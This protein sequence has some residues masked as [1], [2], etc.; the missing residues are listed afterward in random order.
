M[1]K[2]IVFS[3]FLFISLDINAQVFNASNLSLLWAI[4]FIL[5]ILSIA[6]FPV[7]I[8]HLWHNHYGK[9]IFFITLIFLIIVNINYGFNFTYHLV[10]HSILSE[11]LPF[12]ILLFSLYTVSSGIFLSGSVEG[13]PKNNTIMLLIGSILSSLMGTTGSTMLLIRPLIRANNERKSKA[14]IFVFLIILVAN[15]GGGLTPIGDP[16][17]FLGFL[18]GVSF[19]WNFKSMLLPVLFN[20]FIL[21]FVFYFID[22]YYYDKEDNLDN[23]KEK[24]KIS[25]YGKY[26][27]LLILLI[28]F[29]VILFGLHKTQ[30]DMQTFEIYGINLSDILRDVLLFIIAL[31][32]LYFTP[33]Q[34][35]AVNDFNWEPIKEVAKLFF[36]IFIT[37]APVLAILKAGKSGA[38]NKLI[39]SLHSNQGDALNYLYFWI[40]GILSSFLDN[41]PTY[42]VFFN[43]ANGDANYMMNNMNNTLLAISMG[44]VFFGCMTYVGN[45]PNFMVKSIVE[46]K[47]IKMP[48]FF[49]YMKWTFIIL[50]PLF[51]LDT[52]IFLLN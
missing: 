19:Y 34:V 38:L 12:I 33:K 32:S 23:K 28:I 1:L 3:L 22:K 21:L 11:Y 52:L 35:R 48:S 25:F 49:A 20:E 9:I 5:V 4:P 44:S 40:C 37:I 29:T 36:G 41:A 39:L 15:I 47:K 46:Q 7:F 31:I 14:H 42:L 10:I 6:I 2:R 30:K 45:A 8:P 16:P 13:T 17:L 24:H 18:Q 51:I 27:F 26:N 43:V 50:I